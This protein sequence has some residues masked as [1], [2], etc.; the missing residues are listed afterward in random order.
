LAKAIYVHAKRW[1]VTVG[2]PVVQRLQAARGRF[3]ILE[4][5]SDEQH[6]I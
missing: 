4:H 3:L 1:E 2:R 6:L 5:F